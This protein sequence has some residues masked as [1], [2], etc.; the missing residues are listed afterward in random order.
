MGLVA[1]ASCFF[2]AVACLSSATASAMAF[3]AVSA[4]CRASATAL[5]ATS[6]ASSAELKTLDDCWILHAHSS[7]SLLSFPLHVFQGAMS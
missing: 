4:A 5:A 2:I 3:S 7:C 1:A 6:A